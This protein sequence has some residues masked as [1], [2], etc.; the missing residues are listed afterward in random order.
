MEE[1]GF[2]RQELFGRPK[3]ARP[4]VALFAV[5]AV[6]AAAVAFTPSVAFAQ[7]GG[8]ALFVAVSSIGNTLDA[9][10]AN[11]T[12]TT[13]ATNHIYDRIIW[14][15][16]NF[17]FTPGVADSWQYEDAT[18]F[19][20]TLADGFVFHNGAPLTPEDVV[21]SIERLR[22]IPRVASVM[23]NIASVEVTGDKEI[24]ITLVEPHSATIRSLM[25]ETHV[26]NKA[27]A[28]STPDY[29]NKPVGTGP[30]VV[31]NFVPG[32]RLELAAWEG[33]P[34]GQ[35]AIKKI[36]FKTIEEPANRFI[37]METG[38]AQF[39]QINYQ[40]LARAE[41]HAGLHVVQAQTTN[42]AFISMN[43]QQPPFDNRNVRLALAYATDR[44]GL[45]VVQGGATPIYSMTPSM[46]T[47]YYVSEDAPSFDLAKAMELLA[48]EGYGPANPLRFDA[49]VYGADT[50]VIEAYQAI[51]KAIGVE[52][53]IRNLEFGVF[54][55]GVSRGEYQLL[56]GSWNNVTGN[57]LSALEYY[58]SGSFGASNI[59][60]F[61]DDRVDELYDLAKA[62]ADEDVLKAA[63]R[64]VQD[65]AAREMPI[66]PT[67]SSLAIFTM[68]KNLK[69]VEILPS[70]IY[71]FRN[72]YFE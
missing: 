19:T 68:D 39:A 13:I 71:S 2:L 57:P 59:S 29:V 69:G 40:D 26:Y 63:A 6:L 8:D 30:Y 67:F 64:E 33:Y 17:E 65:I 66:I 70:S 10:V 56:A 48:L 55:E 22:D 72:A 18:T 47:T 15:D 23:S 5:V 24:T 61:Q 51:L 12:N 31:A 11:F 35:P 16:E 3:G 25:A 20:F 60:F 50:S 9:T 36:T 42:T 32:D 41:R 34:F 1:L 4:S 58:W 46:F 52:M 28:E 49:W 21:F 43:A 14:F 53:S 38:E 44:E 54:L 27:Y 7:S 37:A 45:A 62:S